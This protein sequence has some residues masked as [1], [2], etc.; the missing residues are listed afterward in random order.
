MNAL[1]SKI[2][3]ALIF[4]QPVLALLC[5]GFSNPITWIMMALYLAFV[6]YI[7]IVVRPIDTIDFSSERA[8]NGHLR[9]NWLKYPVWALAMWVTFVLFDNLY[10]GQWLDAAFKFALVAVI[11]VIYVRTGTWGS[12]WCFV[13]NAV[14]LVLLWRVFSKDICGYVKKKLAG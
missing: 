4:I 5:V 7:M 8:S 13:A 3:F 2:G 6:V 11:Y 10:R 9:W 14:S 1:W 12:L